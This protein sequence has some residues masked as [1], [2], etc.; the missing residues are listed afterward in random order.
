MAKAISTEL[1]GGSGFTFE[2]SVVAYYLTALAHEDSAA[3]Q[4]GAVVRVAVQQASHGEPLD[5]LVVDTKIKGEIRRL[6]LQVKRKFIISAASSNSAFRETIENC[7]ITR[8]KPD[9]R[10]SKDRYGFV[11]EYVAKD[12]L[13]NL[14]RLIEWAIASTTTTEF[15]RRFEAGGSASKDLSGL[16]NNLKTLIK[17]KTVDDEID[18]Y[19]HLVALRLDGLNKNGV[20]YSESVNRLKTLQRDSNGSGEAFFSILCHEARVGAGHQKVWTRPI[21]LNDI[22][23]RLELKEAPAYAGDLKTIR[24]L[25]RQ[26]LQDISTSISGIHI[27]RPRLLEQLETAHSKFRFVNISGQPGTGKSALLK[28]YVE[29]PEKAGPILFLKSDRLSGSDWLSFA[30]SL[31]L[32]HNE[33][34]DL[35]AEIGSAG[36]PTL[37]VDG[38]DRIKG[39]QR[40]IVI[41]LLNAISTSPALKAWKMVATSRDQGLEVVRSWVPREFYREEGIGDASVTF[42]DD[43]EAE[44][45][46][47]R[48]PELR[49]LLFGQTQVQEI[50]RRPFFAA[51]LAKEVVENGEVAK[52]PPQT[53][54]E[55]IN[56]W[57]KAGG[58]NAELEQAFARQRALIDLAEAGA[59][60]LG[61]K[62]PARLLSHGTNTVVPTLREDEVIR[63]VETGTS[64]SFTH[65]IFFEWAFMKLLTDKGDGWLHA[66]ASTG[67]P[68]LLARI[69]GLFSQQVIVRSG[70]EWIGAYEALQTSNLRPQWRRAWLLGPPASPRFFE[71]ITSFDELLAANDFELLEKFL[72]WFQAEQ[73]MPNPV[74]LGNPGLQID[75]DA[76]VRAAD[77]LGWPSD[78]KAWHRVLVWTLNKLPVVPARL[79]P[80]FVELFSV[81]QNA[82]KD[83]DN[84]LSKRIIECCSE[85][86]LDLEEVTYREDFSLERGRWNDLTDQ[87]ISDLEKALR[88]VIIGAARCYPQ[89]AIA[90]FDRAINKRRLRRELYSELVGYSPIISLVAPEK[91]FELACSELMNELPKDE[92]ERERK[93]SEERCAWIESILAKREEERTEQESRAL[94]MPGPLRGAKSYD[95]DDIG[96]DRYGQSYYPTT[97]LNE[98]F[99]S[100]FKSA[101]DTAL[102]LVRTLAN[103]AMEGWRQVYELRKAWGERSLRTPIPFDLKFPWGTQRLWGSGRELS[104]YRGQLAPQ[105]LESAFLA[106]SYWAHKQLDEGRDIDAIIEDVVKGHKCWAVLGL[107]SSLALEKYHVSEVILPI[108]TCQRLWH[109]DFARVVQETDSDFVIFGINPLNDIS[110]EKREAIEYLKGRASRKQSVCDLAPYFAHCA[111]EMLREK[112]K[113]ALSDFPNN[114]PYFFEEERES[115]AHTASL[116]ETARL[117]SGRGDKENYEERE[118]AELPGAKV[119]EYSAPAPLPADARARLQESNEALR[120]YNLLAWAGKSLDA[121]ALQPGIGLNAAVE[122]VQEYDSEELFTALAEAGTGAQQSATSAIAALVIRHSNSASEIDRAWE[123]LSRVE[124]MPANQCLMSRSAN[125]WHPSLHLVMA[126]YA[127]L[128]KERPRPDSAERLLKLT[129]YPHEQVM[130]LAFSALFRL[131]DKFPGLAWTAATLASQLFA[132]HWP[133]ISEGGAGDYS[134][135][136][137]AKR[138]A[139][140][141][142]VKQPN[143]NAVMPFKKVPPAWVKAIPKQIHSRGRGTMTAVW[144]E[145]DEFFNH[146][147]AGKIVR[148]FPVEAWCQS[149]LYRAHYLDYLVQ[150]TNWTKSR[151]KPAWID[152]DSSRRDGHNANV[153]EWIP[154]LADLFSRSSPFVPAGELTEKHLQPFLLEDE[155]DCLGVVADFADTLVCRHVYDA[156]HITENTLNLL[157]ACVDRLLSDQVFEPQSYRAGKVHGHELPKLIRALLLVSVTGAPRA[158]RFAN[159]NWSEVPVVMPL[160]DKLMGRTGWSPYVMDTYL[161]LCERA[162]TSIPADKFSKHIIDALDALERSRATWIGLAHPARISSVVQ[163]LADANDPLDRELARGF[164]IVLDRLI[165]LGDRRSAALQQSEVFRNIKAYSD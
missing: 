116:L 10:V 121:H 138:T 117:W 127:D 71:H 160:I 110:S 128:K 151:I 113:Q 103:H 164:L 4:S 18:F 76:L 120:G 152:Q 156:A 126:L 137:A 26:S 52:A 66:M 91:L 49:P 97:P 50:A 23:D 55:L 42:F 12:N 44:R 47:E 125:P 141:E 40:N 33:P 104:W 8:A 35:L 34:E 82:F 29:A 146:H 5:D 54:G 161:T 85:W 24:I 101:P 39:A 159:G 19:E 133:E 74:I 87:S 22:K 102:K 89:P 43:A 67:E 147:I 106:L 115:P 114:L 14:E 11:A 45:L 27:E 135:E 111:N 157:E 37:F 17:P 20:R 46:A 130:E 84:P 31:G 70:S 150:L 107:A 56:L 144:R 30:T 6:S 100:L 95:L 123:I 98:P 28:G 119:V 124:A 155:D 154:E 21:L 132:S 3:G 134:K 32:K 94:S 88:Q 61:R 75:R 129:L 148:H 25:A 83:I 38:I 59:P 2:D 162:G 165:D 158:N 149:D 90:V 57:W 145:P 48:Q 163:K 118:L 153:F 15:E 72:V 16:R 63:D 1:T 86:L 112:F 108:A 136:N 60:N 122:Y 73:T 58:H 140:E 64:L 105:A 9:F 77:L 93:E 51:V 65:D 142:A 53:E 78:F 81:W 36:E 68:P 109:A 62:I 13:R 69:V 99:G 96:F 139:I 41:D 79:I 131:H 80:H 143:S 7:L 92:I